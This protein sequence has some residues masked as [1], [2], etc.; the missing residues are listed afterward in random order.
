[1]YGNAPINFSED[2]SKAFEEGEEITSID[3]KTNPNVIPSEKA[4]NKLVK[5][6]KARI[7][8]CLLAVFLMRTELGSWL[9][10]GP[11]R[12]F[13]TDINLL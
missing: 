10:K 4:S 2:Q 7:F 3:K 8:H 9:V 1:M 13:K 11:K 6:V 12:V 5:I